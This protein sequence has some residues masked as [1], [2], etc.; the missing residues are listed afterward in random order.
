MN[1]TELKDTVEKMIKAETCCQELKDAGNAYLKAI[2]T[3]DEKS[4]AVSL[5]KECREDI[6]PIDDLIAFADSEKAVQILGAEASEGMKK[7]ASELKAS[8]AKYCD[9]PACA[10]AQTVVNNADIITK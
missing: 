7:H 8:G 3:S 9:C 1:K 10:A 5:V 2:G 6:L 4:K